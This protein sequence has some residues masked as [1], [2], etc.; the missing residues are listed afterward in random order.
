MAS[1][2]E[3][4]KFK[5]LVFSLVLFF[6]LSIIVLKIISPSLTGGREII[7]AAQTQSSSSPSAPPELRPRTSSDESY[8][9]LTTLTNKEAVDAPGDE[10]I[11]QVLA[12]VC[13]RGVA[14]FD[15]YSAQYV[16]YLV[17]DD[18]GEDIQTLC[19]FLSLPFHYTVAILPH[20]A[21]SQT[22][23]ELL[24]RAGQEVI[25]HLPMEPQGMEDPGYGAILV[26]HSPQEIEQL[27]ALNIRA[28]PHIVG[29]NNHMGSKV[30][31][32]VPIM[33]Q[34]IRYLTARSLFFLDS[35]T[36]ANSVALMVAEQ[37]GTQAHRRHIF[38]D[39]QDS[40]QD[41]NQQLNK[42]VVRA[43]QQGHAIIIG[44]V[45]GTTLV[46]V[47]QDRYTSLRAQGVMFA[48]LSELYQQ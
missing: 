20:L 26:Q 1:Q 7:V 23:A 22:S 2:A 39:N 32:H 41:I 48:P 16:L 33:T 10:A 40:Y 31:A 3:Q 44:H 27:L 13:P 25:L 4:Q 21:H 34:V 28:V 6:I 30:T 43:Q 19:P 18:A 45:T 46:Q 36:A 14:A 29:V 8:G 9:G 17:L 47:L 12:G 35:R 11:D 38:L 37:L 42:A 5:R 15:D 24:H